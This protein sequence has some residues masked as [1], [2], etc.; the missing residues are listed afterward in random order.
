MAS[1]ELDAGALSWAVA[2]GL[3]VTSDG[4]GARTLTPITGTKEL[5]DT[6][7]R[8]VDSLLDHARCFRVGKKRKPSVVV[9]APYLRSVLADFGSV[10]ATVTGIHEVAAALKL[11]VRVGVASDNIYDVGEPVLPLVWWNPA[12]VEL[13]ELELTAFIT[14]YNA[15]LQEA[16]EASAS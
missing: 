12:R 9:S 4:V 15:E 14:A 10:A 11:R 16:R 8:A 13:E 1:P 2:R 3:K 7:R 6:M 5:P